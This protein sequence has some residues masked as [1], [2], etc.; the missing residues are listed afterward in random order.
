MRN[1]T[2]ITANALLSLRSSGLLLLATLPTLSHTELCSFNRNSIFFSLKFLTFHFHNFRAEKYRKFKSLYFLFEIN[3][4][5]EE[6][7]I[8]FK[9]ELSIA[10][11]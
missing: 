8:Y 9:C 3:K 5:G 11:E 2:E 4:K 6:T 1:D 10:H 7:T